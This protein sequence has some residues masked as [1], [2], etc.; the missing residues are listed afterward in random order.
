[1][2]TYNKHKLNDDRETPNRSEGRTVNMQ[3][4][5]DYKEEGSVWGG[6]RISQAAAQL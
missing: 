4:E 3:I 6:G 2:G 1:M 5:L